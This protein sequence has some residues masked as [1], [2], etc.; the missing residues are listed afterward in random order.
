MVTRDIVGLAR[1]PVAINGHA[2]DAV[3]DTGAGFS[4]VTETAAKKL[5]VKL[6]DRAT[7]VTSAS[8]DD[9]ATRLGVAEK[10]QFGDA[11]LTNVVFIVLP[12]SALSFAGGKYNIEAIVGLP[13]FEALRR[14][15]LAKEEGKEA[16]YYGPKAS[17]PAVG[18]MIFDGVEPVV[19]AEAGDAHLRLFIDTGATTTS[20]NGSA[21]RDYPAL[22]AEA[23][24]ATVQ[25]QGAG[26][27]SDDPGV[28]TVPTLRLTI[29]GRTFDLKA[30]TMRSK[31]LNG[32]HGDIGQDILK[33]G[34][35]WALDFE[36]MSFTV[37]D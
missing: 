8:K 27:P 30:I 22:T 28:M 3:A 23:V 25:L 6:L 31:V 14:I 17:A 9:V 2:I 1:I 16:L 19:L 20:L 36:T 33:Q 29:A 10:L 7:T 5:G 34:T 37:E 15:E 35:R 26:G 11:E 21:A 24:K 12:D 4:T 18:N 32:H 13:V